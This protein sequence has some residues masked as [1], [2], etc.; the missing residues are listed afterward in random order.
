MNDFPLI[1]VIVPVYNCEK[2]LMA[3][4]RSVLLQTY[5]NLE[6]ILVDDGS[7]DAS[8]KICDELATTEERVTVYHQQNGGVSSARNLGLEN[9]KGKYI[10]FVDADDLWEENMLMTMYEYMTKEHCDIVACN[11]QNDYSDGRLKIEFPNIKECEVYDNIMAINVMNKMEG[12]AA[13]ACNKLF[14]RDLIRDV[15]FPEGITVGEDYYFVWHSLIKAKRVMMCPE[16]LFHY[17]QHSGS[18][19]HR[20]YVGKSVGILE[21]YRAIRNEADTEYPL[22]CDTTF[23]YCILQ[24][25][26]VVI[27]MIRSD[28]YDIPL[29]KDIRM[30]IKRNLKRYVV[31]K[32]TPIHLKICALLLCMHYKCL[33]IPYRL[34]F[35]KR[36]QA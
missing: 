20:G 17:V 6:V 28:T 1:T 16:A 30:E 21:N 5:N 4:V 11:M 18:A 23:S 33:T 25:M 19:C 24:E 15:R 34:F 35:K 13:S 12:I 2:Y 8:G 10:T 26:A 36:M 14:K 32:V 3:T 7:K 31:S 27:S 22:L 9:A 29:I